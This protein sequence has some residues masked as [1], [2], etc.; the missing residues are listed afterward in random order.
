MIGIIVAD[1]NEISNFPFK[2][3]SKK[4]INQFEFI[5]YD[6]DIVFI[7]SGI[8]IANAASATQE[9]ISS[10]NIKE[11]INY[12]AI[13]A[14]T[15]LNIFDIITPEKIYYHDVLTPWYKR[16]KTPGEKNYYKNGIS[17][18]NNYNLASGSSFITDEKYINDLK[19]E[20][21]VDI[22]DMET[23]GIAQIADKNNIEIII[24]KV[25]S[26]LI[27]N[28]NADNLENINIRIQKAGKIAFN[29]VLEYLKN[30]H[31]I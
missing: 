8:G 4:K 28:T 16:G 12:G 31:G 10:F 20:L 9:L 25:V 27:G 15:N 22:F 18:K 19:K 24:F 14:S 2:I 17:S 11:I 29:K 1:K 13:G 6:N 23:A 3:K 7:N 5:I 21:N 30:K 26:D